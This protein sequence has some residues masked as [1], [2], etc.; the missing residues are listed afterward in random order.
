MLC[1]VK[2]KLIYPTIACTTAAVVATAF[3]ATAQ[4]VD[5]RVGIFLQIPPYTCSLVLLCPCCP[6]FESTLLDLELEVQLC[7]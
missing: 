1:A 5:I 2:A 3:F 4:C 7:E 6:L